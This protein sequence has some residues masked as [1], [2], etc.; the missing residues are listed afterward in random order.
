MNL[1]NGNNLIKILITFN[2][3]AA[4]KPTIYPNRLNHCL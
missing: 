4:I 2:S 3:L 1:T